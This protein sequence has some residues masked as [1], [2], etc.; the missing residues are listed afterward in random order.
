M[1]DFLYGMFCYAVGLGVG[2]SINYN[3]HITKD[4]VV[5]AENVCKDGAWSKINTSKIYCSDGG[6]YGVE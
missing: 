4:N 3:D 2:Y 6:V 1:E 5:Q